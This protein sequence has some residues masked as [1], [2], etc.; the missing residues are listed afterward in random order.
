MP[1]TQQPISFKRWY[2]G[3]R[4]PQELPNTFGIR[5]DLHTYV[6]SRTSPMGLC[7]NLSVAFSLDIESC[8]QLLMGGASKNVSA[9]P[10]V[11]R[12]NHT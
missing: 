10:A 7:I 6:S 9:T 12:A 5:Y 3:S 4:T 1:R 11:I 8:I 2:A